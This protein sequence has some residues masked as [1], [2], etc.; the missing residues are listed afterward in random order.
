[1][2][3][4]DRYVPLLDPDEFSDVLFYKELE[5][6]GYRQVLLGGTGASD[7]STL[8]AKIKATTNLTVVLYP[9]G[10]DSVIDSADVI[11]LPDVMNSNSHFARPF[12]SGAVATAMN[13]LKK[14]IN[15]ISVAYFILGNSTARW[16]YDAFLIRQ[17]KLI[18]GYA[19][20]ARMLGYRF[21][22]LDY[23]DPD[24]QINPTLIKDL[25]LIPDLKLVISDEFTP[26]TAEVALSL[27]ADVVITPSDVLEAASDPIAAASEFY[28]K[29]LNV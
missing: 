5:K 29:L 24:M 13:I 10:P 9:A 21:L 7:L 14:R 4:F 18:M 22:A 8:T 27:G 28:E 12:G 23:E 16:Y 17:S 1:M 19:N 25:K 2:F 3:E 11:I 6:I 20:Y 26:S 15:Y